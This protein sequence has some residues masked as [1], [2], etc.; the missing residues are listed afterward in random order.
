[1]CEKYMYTNVARNVLFIAQNHNKSTTII[2]FLIVRNTPR[3][4]TIYMNHLF[5][6]SKYLV[7]INI[8]CKNFMFWENIPLQSLSISDK[9]MEKKKKNCIAFKYIINL[10]TH[11]SSREGL[12][13]N[14]RSTQAS[15]VH[16]I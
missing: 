1:M 3:V 13:G 4:H 9:Q 16:P 10:Q 5:L 12:E 2:I 11:V 6:P 8:K 14:Q 15:I 7:H